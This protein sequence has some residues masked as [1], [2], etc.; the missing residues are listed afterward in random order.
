MSRYFLLKIENIVKYRF[1]CITIELYILDFFFL[2][3]SV[4]NMVSPFKKFDLGFILKSAREDKD[5]SQKKV[6]ELTGI[7]NKTLS[8][9]ENNIAE[10]DFNTLAILIQLYGLSMDNILFG[11]SAPTHPEDELIKILRKLPPSVRDDVTVQIKALAK[12]Y[13]LS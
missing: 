7:N 13:K 8:G 12:K 5:L 2:T 4:S 3:G 1:L 9:Y 11:S 10:P 6:M